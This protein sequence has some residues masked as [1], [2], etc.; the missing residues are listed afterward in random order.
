MAQTL[1]YEKIATFWKKS[2]EKAVGLTQAK[3]KLDYIAGQDR[4]IPVS[5][6]AKLRDA[7]MQFF[8][9]EVLPSLHKETHV[10]DLGCGPGV[11]ALELAPLVGHVTGIDIAPAF[12]THANQ[13]AQRAG[14]ENVTFEVA[15]FLAFTPKEQF[16]LILLGAMLVHVDDPELLPLLAKVRSCL[17][18]NGL[19]YVRSS[20]APRRRYARTGRYQ[21]LYRTK[22]EYERAFKAAGFAFQQ[23]RD[24]AYTDASLAA[25]YFGAANLVTLGMAKRVESVGMRLYQW[26]EANRPLALD[27]ARV[28]LDKTPT[29]ISYHFVLRAIE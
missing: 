15:S 9:R 16:D 8:R 14:I 6:Q 26:L 11:W 27:G 1:D 19:V 3:E 18:P 2:T 22:D 13:E 25:V 4:M 5:V 23:E 29:P 10:L 20:L 7:Q 21:A 17:R 12:I 24:V 28:L